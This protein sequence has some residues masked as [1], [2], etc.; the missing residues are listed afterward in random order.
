L[1]ECIQKVK[2]Y[3]KKFEIFLDSYVKELD[4]L[5]V[6]F[7]D[8]CDSEDAAKM[9]S[10]LSSGS[11]VQL[12]VA[13]PIESWKIILIEL[14]DNCENIGKTVFDSKTSSKTV[15]FLKLNA[16]YGLKL[17]NFC[18]TLSLSLAL[19]FRTPRRCITS[20]RCNCNRGIIAN[21]TKVQICKSN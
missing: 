11:Q 4:F 9:L 19:C 3:E 21:F 7:S 17:Y 12:D 20:R 14:D 13:A 6:H 15:E 10:E 1:F 16:F 2:D 8:I 18:K 5:K